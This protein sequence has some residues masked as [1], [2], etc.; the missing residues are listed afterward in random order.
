MEKADIIIPVPHIPASTPDTA[1]FVEALNEGDLDAFAPRLAPGVSMTSEDSGQTIRGRLPTLNFFTTRLDTG[2]ADAAGE[3]LAVTGSL[4]MPG[5]GDDVT[6][7]PCAILY[8]GFQKL[9]VM[10]L[11]VDAERLIDR[12]MLSA[13]E[14]TL[15]QAWPIEPPTFRQSAILPA[16]DASYGEH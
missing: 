9:C 5:T 4:R 14:A 3:Q 11:S 6:E 2:T 1:R 15:R 13:R 10:R 12:I 8:D 7:T 16:L